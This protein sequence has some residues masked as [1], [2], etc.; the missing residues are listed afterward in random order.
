MRIILRWIRNHKIA[1]SLLCVCCF[2]IPVI[3]IHVLFKRNKGP[4]WL[5]ANWNAGDALSYVAGFE[6]FIGTVTLGV[7]SLWQNEQIHQ[8][9]IDSLEPCLSMK[10]ILIDDMLNL[11]V[12]NTGATEAKDISIRI[13]NISNNGDCSDLTNGGEFSSPFELYP[14]EIVQR[15]IAASGADIKKRIFPQVKLRVSY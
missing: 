14:K 10:L 12:E 5:Q 3:I 8:E 6:A 15:E 4:S 1:T 7:L 11:I 9:H 13:L 2:I